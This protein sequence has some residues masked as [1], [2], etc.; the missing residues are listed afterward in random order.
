MYSGVRLGLIG[1]VRGLKYLKLSLFRAASLLQ[2]GLLSCIKSSRFVI[3]VTTTTDITLARIF[4]FDCI[5]L[6]CKKSTPWV[7]VMADVNKLR[8]MAPG[9]LVSFSKAYLSFQFFNVYSILLNMVRLVRK[10]IRDDGLISE[11]F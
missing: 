6:F 3:V 1:I 8:D 2:Y 9:S 5:K 7:R 11:L 10:K 4:V